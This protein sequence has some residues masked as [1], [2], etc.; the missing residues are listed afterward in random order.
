MRSPPN[1]TALVFDHGLF[2]GL[3]RAL[4][5]QYNRV[6]YYTPWERGFPTINDC[7]IGDGC[8]MVERCNNFWDILDDI[9]LFVFPDIQHSGLQLHLEAMGKPVWG[10]RKADSLEINR[11]KFLNALAMSGLPT[12]DWDAITGLDRLRE[13]LRNEKDKYI[14][15]SRYRGSM[16][17]WHWH[18][19]KTDEGQLD[20]LAVTLGPAKDRIRFLV[21]EPIDADVEVGYDGYCIDGK[22]P[23][24]GIQGYEAKDRGFLCRIQPYD[25]LPKHV[26]EVN[27]KFGPILAPY[28]YR[29]FWSTEIRDGV[30]I[31]P[32]CRCPSPSTECQLALYSNIGEII[33][34]GAH[35]RLVDPVPRDKFA[36]SA[37][38]TT[39]EDRNFW[40]NVVLPESV[41][42]H[43]Y[44]IRG[45]R[46]EEAIAFP[47]HQENGPELGWLTATG[48][49]PSEAILTLAALAK[50][51]PDGVEVHVESIAELIN[52]IDEA[53]EEGIKFSKDMPDPGIVVKP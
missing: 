21:F 36:A 40:L 45:C 17:T 42:K 48:S 15:I 19:W 16:E 22:F 27:E 10:S 31:D 49:S 2:F 38:V 12:P 26:L 34:E 4:A 3:A 13:A 25:Q 47:P 14:K 28:N 52:Q 5:E 33:W 39:K 1:I 20:Q 6:L 53:Q 50:E 11:E 35:G 30:F 51:V 32:C 29:N 44:F 24:L 37:V 46:F 43:F 23:K 9:D 7:I 41:L 8:D 18:D